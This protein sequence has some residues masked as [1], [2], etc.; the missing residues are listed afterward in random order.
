MKTWQKVLFG[1]QTLAM[2]IA[3]VYGKAK[4]IEA[5]QTVI[6]AIQ[7]RDAVVA[8]RDEADKLRV[9]LKECEQNRLMEASN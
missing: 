1:L 8:V 9:K 6:L 4:G 7:Q 5:E 2:L 3:M